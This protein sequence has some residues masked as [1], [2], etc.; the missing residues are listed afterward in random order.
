MTV[1]ADI[2]AICLSLAFVVWA[3]ALAY[4]EHETR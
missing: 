1:D 3:V 4:I 2:Y